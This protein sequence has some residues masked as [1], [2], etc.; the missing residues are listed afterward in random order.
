MKKKKKLLKSL[1]QKT[2]FLDDPSNLSICTFYYMPSHHYHP[3]FGSCDNTLLAQL[4]RFFII[5]FI[6]FGEPH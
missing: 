6:L 2:L 5:I 1:A 3:S 4:V